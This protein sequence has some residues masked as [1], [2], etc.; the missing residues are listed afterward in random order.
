[1][2]NIVGN[3]I[4][5]TETT[6]SIIIATIIFTFF[7]AVIFAIISQKKKKVTLRLLSI[8]YMVLYDAVSF[9]LPL[10][11]VWW[12]SALLSVVLIF[13]LRKYYEKQSLI[14]YLKQIDA[15]EECYK[16]YISKPLAVISSCIIS[17]M[18]GLVCFFGTSL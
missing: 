6:F 14:L 16:E 9:I 17:Y 4:V 13:L 15:E 12:L 5:A 3:L 1:M 18:C 7:M 2:E 10:L 11:L 8:A